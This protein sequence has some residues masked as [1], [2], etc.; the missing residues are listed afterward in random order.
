MARKNL[1]Q[2][3]SEI[4][5]DLAAN[6]NS[7]IDS[8]QLEGE[9]WFTELEFHDDAPRVE[10]DRFFMGIYLS[11]P[12]GGVFE[13]SAQSQKVT[14]ALDCILD[15]KRENSN[16]SEL[17]LSA[18]LDYLNSRR[19]G[20]SST[21]TYAETARVDLDAD[22]NAFSVAIEVVVYNMDYDI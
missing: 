22:V 16:L 13:G 14:V 21:P 12:D 6:L 18:V 2:I 9:D 3:V 7:F 1:R 19:Y 11:S 8:T 20:V 10:T 5:L 15:D 17:Y 4:Q